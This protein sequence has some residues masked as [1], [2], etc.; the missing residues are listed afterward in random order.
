M[1]GNFSL[2]KN[3]FPN[4]DDDIIQLILQNNNCIE[5]CIDNLLEINS[6]VE[7]R[8]NLQQIA[9]AVAIDNRNT[10]TDTDSQDLIPISDENVTILS[11]CS[12]P[13]NSN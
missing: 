1:N 10:S 7:S 12:N 13:L 9:V 8:D 5:V 3:I 4:I 2:L 6:S 11:E